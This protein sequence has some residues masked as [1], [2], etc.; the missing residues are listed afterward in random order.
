MPPGTP[1]MAFTATAT[2]S[3]HIEVM[4]LLEMDD[5]I[6]ISS[7][8]DRCNI[9]YEVCDCTSVEWDLSWLMGS[10]RENLHKT[11]QVIVYCQSLDM[12]ASLYAHFHFELGDVSYYPAGVVQLSE[13]R[14]F[15][16][17]HASTSQHNKDIILQSLMKPDGIVKVVGYQKR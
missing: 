17:F 3:V 14:L 7:S 5:C 9:F 6:E 2:N 16:M 8:P 12:C 11:P 4:K 13:N 15:G 10:F 1:Y